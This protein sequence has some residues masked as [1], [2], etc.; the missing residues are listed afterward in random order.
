M[1]SEVRELPQSRVIGDWGSCHV[2]VEI[3]SFLVILATSHF[4]IV[5]MIASIS[6]TFLFLLFPIISM[7]DICPDSPASVH[8]SCEMTVTFEETCNLVKE[9]IQARLKSK[10]WIDPHNQGT[11][12]L[13]SAS[14]SSVNASRATGDALYTDKM[15]LN[16]VPTDKGGCKVKACSVSQVTSI[17][18]FSTNYCNLRNL[19]CNSKADGCPV[20]KR[21]LNYQEAYDSCWQRNVERCIST[22]KTS[23]SL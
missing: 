10:S 19:Y 4:S 14:G 11:Y 5:T 7:A 18:D 12:K 15:A 3:P 9:E 21:D 23:R 8:A 13:D 20:I 2:I 1:L 6:F 22:R 16:F 17:L